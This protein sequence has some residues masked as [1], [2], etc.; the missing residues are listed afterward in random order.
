MNV[1]TFVLI[2]YTAEVKVYFQWTLLFIIN[3]DIDLGVN[4]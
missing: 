1:K 4:Q 2:K 3:D